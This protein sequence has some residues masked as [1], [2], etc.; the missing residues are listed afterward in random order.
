MNEK[1]EICFYTEAHSTERLNIFI[2][3][4]PIH[5]KGEK[6][7]WKGCGG[8]HRLRVEQVKMFKSKWYLVSAPAMFLL[9]MLAYEAEFD[10]KTPFYA[11]YEADIIVDKSM[12]IKVSLSDINKYRDVSEQ[13]IEYKI[14]VNFPKET[15][16]NVIE[17]KIFATKKER[18]AWFLMHSILFSLLFGFM[19]FVAIGVG[20]S[21]LNVGVGISGAIFSWILAAILISGW[22][23]MM[24]KL[25]K[26]SKGEYKK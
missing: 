10:G 4:N 9:S 25:Y 17:D 8:K 23:F 6:Y 26:H 22:I 3:N 11:V 24:W 19:I 7:I 18:T 14:E 15:T 20:F 1:Y 21:S 12:N 16:V 13:G 2:D 5:N